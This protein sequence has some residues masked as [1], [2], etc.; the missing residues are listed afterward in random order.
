MNTEQTMNEPEM[1]TKLRTIIVV[2]CVI[3]CILF[4]RIVQ[5]IQN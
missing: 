2:C 4:A 1:S 5:M 3:G